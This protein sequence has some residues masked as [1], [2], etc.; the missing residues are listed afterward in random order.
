MDH[1]GDGYIS[2]EEL[3]HVAKSKFGD[4]VSDIMVNNLFSLA[5]VS[6]DGKISRAEIA[7]K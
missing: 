6:G 3:L 7:G 1:D 4:E 5:D 2:K